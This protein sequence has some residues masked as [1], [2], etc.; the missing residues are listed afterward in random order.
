MP[1]QTEGHETKKRKKERPDHCLTPIHVD[2]DVA[3]IL[4]PPKQ[5]S[6]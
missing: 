4:I 5:A 1:D 3:A 6:E 2:C